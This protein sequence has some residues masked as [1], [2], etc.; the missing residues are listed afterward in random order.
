MQREPRDW[1]V[2]ERGKPK[3]IRCDDDPEFAGRA[4]R[5]KVGDAFKHRPRGC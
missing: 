2:R 1:I 4:N 3:T 5:G